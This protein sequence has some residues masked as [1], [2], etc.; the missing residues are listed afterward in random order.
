[1]LFFF[2]SGRAALRAAAA[3]VGVGRAHLEALGQQSGSRGKSVLQGDVIDAS[4]FRA[5]E[6]GVGAG[7]AV[8]TGLPLVDGEHP[9]RSLFRQQPQ[10]VVDGGLRKG[11]DAARQCSVDFFHGGVGGMLHEIFHHGDALHGRLDAV[12]RQVVADCFVA[13]DGKSFL[14][15][16]YYN[17]NFSAK[18][19]F[20]SQ[21]EKF[22]VFFIVKMIKTLLSVK[23]FPFSCV[24]IDR[25]ALI[26]KPKNNDNY[27]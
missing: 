11:G 27:E 26:H 16:N 6:V 24:F 21:M 9:G 19:R 3:E 25:A 22:S 17:F 5:E 23:Y 15:C 14:Y 2:L 18:M 8:E 13:H 7:L 20:F 12:C 10:C 4:A 1:M